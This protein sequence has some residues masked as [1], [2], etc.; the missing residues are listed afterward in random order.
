[1]EYIP[2]YQ[3]SHPR[4]IPKRRVPNGD[5][6]YVLQS[7]LEPPSVSLMRQTTKTGTDTPVTL[8]IRYAKPM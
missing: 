5:Q 6:G 4:E 1:M 7:V 2:P 3:K 8:P